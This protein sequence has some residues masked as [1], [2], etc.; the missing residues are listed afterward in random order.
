MGACAVS[1]EDDELQLDA[2]GGAV[3]GPARA[4][5]AGVLSL[6][7]TGGAVGEAHA[8]HTAGVHAA[9]AGEGGQLAARALQ[10]GVLTMEIPAAGSLG[11][12]SGRLTLL[13]VGPAALPTQ[14]KFCVYLEAYDRQVAVYNGPKPAEDADS[15]TQIA[16]DGSFTFTQWWANA[17]L[18]PVTPFVSGYAFPSALGNCLPIL[19]TPASANFP[20]GMNRLSVAHV[21][22]PRVNTLS[23]RLAAGH[24]SY[25]DDANGTFVL[26]I[27]GSPPNPIAFQILVFSAWLPPPPPGSPLC[28]PLPHC[29][30]PPSTSPAL[31]LPGLTAPWCILGR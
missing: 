7:A 9:A 12:I 19:G 1:Q 16:P 4:L 11:P 30:P 3:E 20:A 31:S 29:P 10:A 23:L 13:P 17:A 15:Y 26:T 24:P 21:T 28:P 14:Y 5:Q 18:D 8:L 27:L 25:S 6:G 22:L 2:M